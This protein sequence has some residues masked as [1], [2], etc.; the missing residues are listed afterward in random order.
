[1]VVPLG[2]NWGSQSLT[3]TAITIL[4]SLNIYVL[5]SAAL[6]PFWSDQYEHS[7]SCIL[8]LGVSVSPVGAGL[9]W[10]A[11]CLRQKAQPLP[12]VRPTEEPP[13]IKS[14]LHADD[15][16]LLASLVDDLQ[17]ALELSVKLLG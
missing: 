1:M 6:P 15:L 8:A 5:C 3:I 7:G 13:R 11:F 9:L 16:A 4:N 12:G 14:L 10:H 17:R 2:C